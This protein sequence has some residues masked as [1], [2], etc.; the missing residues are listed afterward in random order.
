[1]HLELYLQMELKYLVFLEGNSLRMAYFQHRPEKC[2]KIAAFQK[3]RQDSMWKEGR[4]RK[5]EKE[6]ILL[7][8]IVW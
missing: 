3:R 5:E 7:E 2:S 8:G 4:E 6:N 1:M